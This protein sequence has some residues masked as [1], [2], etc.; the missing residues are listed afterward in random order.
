MRRPIAAQLKFASHI[1]RH[2]IVY[3]QFRQQ[4]FGGARL[5]QAL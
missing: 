5:I 4:L 3:H 2:S 1:P